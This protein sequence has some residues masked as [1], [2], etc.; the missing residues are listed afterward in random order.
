MGRQR[1]GQNGGVSLP[2][3]DGVSGGGPTHGSDVVRGA[4]LE[5]EDQ[6]VLSSLGITHSSSPLLGAQKLDIARVRNVYTEMTGSST[7]CACISVI[8][9]Y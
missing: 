8:E 1:V 2:D 7:R 3:G 4:I 6:V 5:E 9:S